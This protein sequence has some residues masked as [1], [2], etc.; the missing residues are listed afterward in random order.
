MA[1]KA[2]KIEK[3]AL[4]MDYPIEIPEPDWDPNLKENLGEEH[5]MIA[6]TQTK[7]EFIKEKIKQYLQGEYVAQLISEDTDRRNQIIQDAKSESFDDFVN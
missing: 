7:I 5:P 6:N 3:L 4:R 1:T 2:E